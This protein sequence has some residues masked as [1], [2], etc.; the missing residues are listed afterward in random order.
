ML[1]LLDFPDAILHYSY[2]NFFFAVLN[3][4]REMSCRFR[5]LIFF[6]LGSCFCNFDFSHLI[7]AG[8]PDNV[9]P[10]FFALIFLRKMAHFAHD[11]FRYP[12]RRFVP[13]YVPFRY[14]RRY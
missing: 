13:S 3:D 4:S 6:T 8:F 7:L 11:F 14:S 9:F 10:L 2:R 1:Q 5:F 12:V